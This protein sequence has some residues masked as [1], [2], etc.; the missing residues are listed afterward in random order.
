MIS[1]NLK[2]LFERKNK[3]CEECGRDPSEV[4]LIAVSKTFGT[5]KILEAYN[6]GIRDFGENKA[7]ELLKKFEAFPHPVNW[8]FIG[9]LQRNKAKY[10]VKT[11]GYIHSVDS[12]ELAAEIN[13]RAEQF[14]KKPNI[15]IEVKTSYEDS[16][17]GI[18]DEEKLE[19]LI[20]FCNGQKNLNL[21]G[22]MTIAPFTDD[23]KIIRQSFSY[24]RKLRHNFIEKGFVNLKELSMGM[25]N[26][27]EIAIEEGSTMIRIGSAIFGDRIY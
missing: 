17:A 9:R 19:G 21:I 8:H 1:E 2:I 16:K 27:F 10:V 3:K 22:L 12:I 18:A 23:E 7:Q 4:K 26:D 20:V 24:L 14:N 6:F 13:K 11:A 15:L 25:T 5:D